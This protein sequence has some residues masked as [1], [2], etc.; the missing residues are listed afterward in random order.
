MSEDDGRAVIE[1]GAIVIRLPIA[2]LPVIV[3]A[4]WAGGKIE[5]RMKVTDAEEFA[6]ELVR[7]LNDE[8][9]DGTTRIH[10]MFDAALEFAFEQ[11]AEGIEIHE[12]QEP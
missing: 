2:N 7:A 10:L 12:N 6:K 5:P 1:D 11:G 9:E 3:D 8:E 4:G